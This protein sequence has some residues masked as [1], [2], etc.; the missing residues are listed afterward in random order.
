MKMVKNI[1]IAL[2]GVFLGMTIIVGFSLY[3]FESKYQS[4]IYPG[5]VVGTHDVSNMFYDEVVNHFKKESAPLLTTF[6]TLEFEEQVATFSGSQIELAYNGDLA[7]T[8][9]FNYGRSGNRG[10]DLT[11]KLESFLYD[12]FPEKF[13]SPLATIPLLLMY[14]SEPFDETLALMAEHINIAPIEPLFEVNPDT[15]RVTAFKLGANGRMLNKETAK[16]IIEQELKSQHGTSF[17]VTLPVDTIAPKASTDDVT[18]LGIVEL[19]G[20]GESLFTGSIPGR[21]HNILLAASRTSGVIV[22]PDQV[23]SFNETVGDISAATGYKTAYVIKNGR[24]VLGDGGGVCQV[25][26]TLFRAALNSGLEIVERS[27]HSYRVGYYELGGYGP[28]LDAT[29]YYPTTDLKIKNNTSHYVLIQ[30]V[31]LESEQKLVFEIYGKKDGREITIGD[32]K[33]LSQSPP[34]PPL[35]QDDPTLPVGQQKQV[36]WA[37]Y[38]AKTSFEYSVVKGK[39]QLV[40]KTFISNFQPWQAVYLVGTKPV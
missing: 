5:V 19:I 17:A 34:P 1:L 25:S 20:R 4:H 32:V 7:A 28:G 36:D 15:K 39:E 16:N 11:F 35:Y 23:F 9:A 3:Q 27:P 26:T 18:E 8:Q 2:L 22:A 12:L 29:V 31:P 30:A 24:T 33:I 6:I 13:K 40:K 21:I 37:A 10:T 38:G 14:K